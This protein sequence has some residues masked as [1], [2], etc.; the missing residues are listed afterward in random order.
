MIQKP[1][2]VL[3]GAKLRWYYDSD[4]DDDDIINR[5]VYVRVWRIF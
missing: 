3:A 2:V 4:V 5:E 1:W